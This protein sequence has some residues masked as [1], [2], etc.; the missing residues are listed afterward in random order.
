MKNTY[1]IQ[2]MRL[3][4]VLCGYTWEAIQKIAILSLK[5]KDGFYKELYDFVRLTNSIVENDDDKIYEIR[6]TDNQNLNGNYV[7]CDSDTFSMVW[8]RTREKGAV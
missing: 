7:A 6:F 1:Y 5:G 3:S 4:D 8:E 2:I